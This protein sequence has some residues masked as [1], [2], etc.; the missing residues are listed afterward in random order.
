MI[1]PAFEDGAIADEAAGSDDYWA[2]DGDAFDESGSGSGDGNNLESGSDEIESSETKPDD[3]ESMDDES[4]DAESSSDTSDTVDDADTDMTTDASDTTGT[5]ESTDTEA[6]TCNGIQPSN[7]CEACKIDACCHDT[8][9]ECFDP[10]KTDGC[11]CVLDCLKIGGLLNLCGLQCG[12][13][14]L[15]LGVADTTFDCVSQSCGQAC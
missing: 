2:E 3:D 12:V 4:T 9:W 6:M 10:E 5:G 1:N 7:D 11:A 15:L 13:L 8:N 14:D